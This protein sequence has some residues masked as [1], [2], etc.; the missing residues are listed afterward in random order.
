[1]QGG[2]FW[3]TYPPVQ[4]GLPNSTL[5][6]V[7]GNFRGAFVPTI[8]MDQYG[9]TLARWLGLQ[10][11]T[12]ATYSSTSTASRRGSSGSLDSRA[13]LPQRHRDTEKVKE[14]DVQRHCLWLCD[15]W[16]LGH[17]ANQMEIFSFRLSMTLLCVSVSLWQ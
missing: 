12:R 4:V 11:P 3:G 7:A 6:S 16:R 13:A 14:R 1:M 5:F 9:N 10:T 8:S 17:S 15:L 2:R